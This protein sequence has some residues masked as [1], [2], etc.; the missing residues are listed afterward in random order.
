MIFTDFL[1]FPLL[2]TVALSV[3]LLQLYLGKKYKP[4]D[5]IPGPVSPSWI[6]GNFKQVFNPGAWAFH[7]L[8]AEKYG[9]MA[10]LH[11]P[12]GTK[13][14]YIFDSKAMHTVLVKDQDVFEES[15]GF[16]EFVLR[17]RHQHR[18]QR[19]MLNPVFSAAHMREMIPTFFQVGHQLESALKK[20]L[21]SGPPTQEVDI[22]SWM[23]RTALEIIGQAGLGYSFDPLTDDESFHPYSKAIKDLFPTLMRVQ[24]WRMN[25]LQYVSRIGS[26]SFRRFVVNLLPW[27]DLH[28]I[29]DMVDY[30]HRTAE[31][32]YESKKRAF[33]MGDEVVSQQIGRG[34]DLISVLMRENLKA[35]SED[36]LQD[37]EVVGQSAMARLLHLLS[38]HP[39]AQ[40]RLR[41]ELVEAK[42]QKDGQDLTYNELTELP[43]LDAICRETLR[44]ARR[45][46]V[47]PLHKPIVGL[48]G[49]EMHE[50]AVPR[51]TTVFVSIFNA[52]RNPDLWGKDANEWKPERWL[53]PL[54]EPLVEARIPGV[55]SHLMTFIGG[56][57]SCIGMFTEVVISILV[58][59][60]KFS[61]SDK[62]SE[63]FWQMNGVTAPVVGKDKHPQLP[64]NISLVS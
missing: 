53:S 59:T 12:W 34:N 9:G 31:E 26:A 20:R 63:I 64:M 1:S 42:R 32:I 44:L 60:F 27:E 43:Y 41:Q 50:V 58:E 30:M 38:K 8:I 19:K 24:F 5:N 40:D 36:R 4:L 52:N 37:S 54:P 61:P 57:R 25:V 22:L 2:G 6:T 11:G 10:R 33:E 47:I 51:G 46:G 7:E 14:L 35:S 16:L 17:I 15:D 62:D 56:G 48:D 18:Q 55:Y 23:G 49:T 29:R 45:D 21:Q 28:H 3:V 13:S 39:E